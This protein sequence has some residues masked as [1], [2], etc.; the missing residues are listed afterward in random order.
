MQAL[1]EVIN[2]KFYK[3]NLRELISMDIFNFR[4]ELKDLSFAAK[5]GHSY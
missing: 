5:I 1:L 3:G 2:F 4:I